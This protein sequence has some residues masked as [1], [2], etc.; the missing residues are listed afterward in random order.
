VVERRFRK[1]R[2]GGSNPFA[3]FFYSCLLKEQANGMPY[4][5]LPVDNVESVQGGP[6]VGGP[7]EGAEDIDIAGPVG[8]QEA[9]N[10]PPGD[11]KTDVVNGEERA[12]LF[13]QIIYLNDV[14]RHA[15]L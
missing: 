15:L 6:S 13:Y 4:L 9:E 7:G 12:V 11:V 8:T 3:G 2:V 14:I 5:V 1:A 10:F